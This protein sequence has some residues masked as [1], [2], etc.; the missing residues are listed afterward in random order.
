M[1]LLR[2]G[3]EQTLLDFKATP[4]HQRQGVDCSPTRGCATSSTRRITRDG[5]VG[6]RRTC[7]CDATMAGASPAALTYKLKTP[8][9]PGLSVVS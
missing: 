7:N 2:A 8:K 6:K 9:S 3:V 4:R 1:G 5:F